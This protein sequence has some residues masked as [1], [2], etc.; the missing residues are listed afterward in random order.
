[1]AYLF[2]TILI[3]IP[4]IF[5]LSS[6]KSVEKSSENSI[7]SPRPKAVNSVKSAKERLME[8]LELKEQDHAELQA[9][10]DKERLKVEKEDAAFIAEISH[11]VP[12]ND[13][14][15]AT[16]ALHKQEC[17]FK[18][19]LEQH[20]IKATFLVLTNQKP[21]ANEKGEITERINLFKIQKDNKDYICLFTSP[22]RAMLTR[23]A[24]KGYDFSIQSPAP[25]IVNQSE[26][27][28]GL[29]INYGWDSEVV[30]SAELTVQILNAIN[31]GSHKN[32]VRF[33]YKEDSSQVTDLFT[34]E[35]CAEVIGVMQKKQLTTDIL[36]EFATGDFLKMKFSILLKKK[37]TRKDGTIS[38]DIDDILLVAG[39]KD[40]PFLA[41][42]SDPKF[43]EHAADEIE[44]L[45]EIVQITATDVLRQLPPAC[46]ILINPGTAL[47]LP[48]G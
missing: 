1:M 33:S 38:F 11:M 41:L 42:F 19:F 34:P 44:L 39:P 30:L 46:G 8:E 21:I 16:V 47:F 24:Q 40:R 22:D 29:V 36:K 37:S 35:K 31:A 48:L 4:V 5:F 32:N 13:F 6:R 2:L 7:E 3:I 18:S 15:K 23:K 10:M 14:E 27:K 26:G 43:I 12:E 20:F 45:E 25:A 28:C 9:K 17:D